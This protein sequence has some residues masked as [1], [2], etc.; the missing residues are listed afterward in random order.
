MLIAHY[1]CMNHISAFN[2]RDYFSLD[3][4]KCCHHAL[5]TEFIS[6]PSWLF[7]DIVSINSMSS[8][9]RVINEYAADSGTRIII[10]QQIKDIRHQ[11]MNR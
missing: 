11:E 9:G 10:L 3:Q 4:N 6:T 1:K 7:S 2:E 8:D 5:A